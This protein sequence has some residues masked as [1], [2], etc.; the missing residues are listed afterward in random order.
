MKFLCKN[1]TIFLEDYKKC[2]KCKEKETCLHY[3]YELEFQKR[4]QEVQENEEKK[5]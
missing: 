3:N 1:E 4:K 5:D 2:L